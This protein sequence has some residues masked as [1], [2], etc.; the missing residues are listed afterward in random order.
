MVPSP[1]G[2]TLWYALTP[3]GDLDVTVDTAGSGFDTVIAAYTGTGL[4]SLTQVACDDDTAVSTSS[5]M[6][7]V[8]LDGVT[9]WIQVGGYGGLAATGDLAL[10]ITGTVHDSAPP[11]WP[12]GSVV[13]ASDVYADRITVSWPAADDPSGVSAYAVYMNGAM[14]TTTTSRSYQIDGLAAKTSYSVRVEAGDANGNWSM[15]AG[16]T[17][18]FTTAQIFTDTAGLVFEDDIEWLSGAAITAGC[19]PPI[20]DQYCPNDFVTR[21]QMAAFLVR[22]LGLSDSGSGD[23]FTDDDGSIFE[24]SID[25]LG[26]AGV[27]QGCNPPINDLFC[28]HDLVTRGQMAAFLVRAVGYTDDGGGNLFSDDDG[29]VFESAI[30]KLGTAG[31]TRGCNPPVNDRFCPNDFVSRGQMAAFL[32]RALG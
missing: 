17:G 22:A 23:L 27:T 26:T 14:L 15:N 1:F 2:A 3:T 10:G 5:Y 16:P 9:Y 25:K 13:D 31:V 7:F 30:D 6:E 11:A 32:R 24:S 20:N 8:A 29:S 12:G 21:G 4:G 19:N 18:T 28:P